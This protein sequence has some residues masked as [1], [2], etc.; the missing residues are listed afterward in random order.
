MSQEHK[1][2][3]EGC[4]LIHKNGSYLLYNP[5]LLTSPEANL[6]CSGIFDKSDNY[7]PVVVGGRGQAWFVEINGLSAVYR[8][9]MRGGLISRIN[10]QTY[11]GIRQEDS[12]SFKEWRL[13]KMM[14]ERNLPVP[15]PIAASINRWP[16]RFS[17]FYRAQILVELIP[18]VQVL[19]QVL[20][21]RELTSEEWGLVGKCIRR[22][23]NEGIYHADLNANNILLNDLS[24]VFLIDF[25][26]SEIRS[27]K[28]GE[29]AWMEANLQRLKRSLLKQ[30]SIH[31]SYH[32]TEN[33]WN[34]LLAAYTDSVS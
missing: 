18:D 7:R 17:P 4:N 9:Y 23:H 20:S 12:R 19:D 10:Q 34:T 30:Q 6:L 22:F 1:N 2:H 28:G 16:F 32:F 21:Q 33:N 27:V 11:L 13:L 8:R 5:H 24:A 29:A 25:D 14:L 31:K 3:S 15:R 26:K